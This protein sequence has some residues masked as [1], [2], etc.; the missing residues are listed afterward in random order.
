MPEKEKTTPRVG[1]Q[2][3]QAEIVRLNKIVQV[4]MNRA[5]RNSNL[6]RSDFNLF[7]ATI[8]LE[9]QVRS[10][11]RELE[12]A[13]QENEK[14]ARTLRESESHCRL[15]IENSPLCIHEIDMDG[16]ITSMNKS[17]LLML[18]LDSETEVQGYSYLDSV[19]TEDRERIGKLLARSYAGETNYFEFKA[20][21]SRGQIYK[22]CF[23]PIKN[24]SGSVEKLMGITEDITERKHI[25]QQ[26]IEREALFRA[27]FDQASIG[28]ELIDLDTLHFIEANPAACRMLGYTH[29]E[30]LQLGLEDT[31]ADM[32]Q[33]AMLATIRRMEISGG[34]IFDNRHRCKNGDILDVEINTHILKL[35]GKR[36][37]V[38]LWRDVTEHKRVQE[39]IKLKN[40]ILQTEQEVSPDAILVVDEN[41]L[42]TSYNQQFLDLWRLSPQMVSAGMSTPVRAVVEQAKNPESFVDRVAYLYQHR[43]QKG[44][45][46]ILLKDGR[47]IDRYSAPI[48]GADGRY[49]GRVWYFRDITERK[50]T[51]EQIRDFA[52]YDILTHL[53]NRRLLNDRL[54]Q[55]MG[56]SKRN[57]YYG[58]VIFLDLDN[59]KPLNDMHGHDVGDLLLIEVA[60]RLS[61]CVREVDT[62]ARVG[63]DEFVVMLS[64]LDLEKKQSIRQAG[65]VAEKIRVALAEPYLLACKQEDERETLVE[66]HCTSSIGVVLFLDH[67]ASLEDILKWADMAMYQAKAHGRDRVHFFET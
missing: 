27:I 31:Q 35:S 46:E 62:V 63:G 17:G 59:F 21:G 12:E 20:S 56:A 37:M 9:D 47:I 26:L 48:K 23:V 25:E 41:S 54:G 6:Q 38:G 52:F 66:H 53:A 40:M 14:I 16:R 50:K 18:G 11:T 34:V 43:D 58:A 67:Q 55:A 33:E 36:L 60:R 64:K 22:S 45:E 65:M 7:Q 61:C 5:E 39:E 51:E 32:D 28:I 13:L 2:S 44:H 49:Y 8:T 15:L 24:K 19:G 1:E 57:G 29:E 42:I 4:L 10:R 3:L 30:F